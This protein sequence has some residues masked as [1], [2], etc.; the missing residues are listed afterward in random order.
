[1]RLYARSSTRKAK[2][3]IQILPPILILV[4]MSMLGFSGSLLARALSVLITLVGAA[5]LIAIVEL[6]ELLP[7][8]PI[9]DGGG[10]VSYSIDFSKENQTK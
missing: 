5:I 3:M 1:M 2:I 7:R 4:A 8:K 10:Q 6:W 9:S